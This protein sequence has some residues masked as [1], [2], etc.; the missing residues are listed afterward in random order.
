MIINDKKYKIIQKNN[1]N[2][3]TKKIK[4]TYHINFMNKY[5]YY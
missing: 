3:P 4:N 2:E 5:H 1:E